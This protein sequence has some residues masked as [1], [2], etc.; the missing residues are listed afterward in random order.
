MKEAELDFQRKKISGF[1]EEHATVVS[2]RI[3]QKIM[4]QFA[5]HLKG[6]SNMTDESIDLIQ[7]VFQLEE[8]VRK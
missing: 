4:N 3:I 1:N 6:D 8:P 5:N 2:D 7:K